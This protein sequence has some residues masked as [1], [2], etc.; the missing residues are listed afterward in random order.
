MARIYMMT[1]AML[2]VLAIP[3]TAQE[4]TA[5]PP[6]PPSPTQGTPGAQGPPSAPGGI[7]PAQLS[8]ANNPLADMNALNFQ[9]F[10][11]PTLYG[12]PNSN[13]NTL[14]LRPVVVSGRQ[15][16]RSTLPISTVPISGGQYQSG[17]GDLSIFDAIKLTGTDA[18]TDF[19]VGPLL[20]APSATDH[21]LGQG[22]WQAGIAAV[23]IQPLPGGSLLGFLTTWQHS[24][25]GLS[26]RPDAHVVTFQPIGTFSIGG[27]YYFRTTAVWV[28][29]IQNGSYLIPLGLGLGKVFKVHGAVVNAFVEPQFT[30]YHNGSGLPS[31]QLFMGL[32]LQFPKKLKTGS[33]LALVVSIREATQTLT[34]QGV[35]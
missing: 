34:R 16:I 29:D 27:G 19:A 20:V 25:A 12:L 4:T 22:K 14:N 9:N 1:V 3:V 33:S 24:F 30:A 17:L 8:N 15:I 21:S 26:D 32:N 18:K 10:Y 13:S 5:A 2:C 28:F 31:I 6:P 23:A 11:A 35:G 7:S